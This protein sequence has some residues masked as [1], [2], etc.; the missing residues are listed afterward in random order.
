MARTGGAQQIGHDPTAPSRRAFGV[1]ATLVTIS[2]LVSIVSSLGAP[3]IPTIAKAESVS[4]ST[5]QWLLTAALLAGALATPVMGRLSDGPRQREVVLAA[6]GAVLVGCLL[7]AV[8]NSFTVVVVGRGLQGV[9][10]GLLPVTMAI[11]RRHLPVLTAVRAIAT[12]SI[13]A[14]IGVGVGYPLTSL[15]AQFF[16]FHAAFWFG[17]IAVS[18]ALLVAALVL[19]GRYEVPT[20]RFDGVGVVSLSLAVVGLSVYLSEGGDWG[21]TSALS[22]SIIGASSVLLALWVA[23][24]LRISDPLVN[25]RQVR[26]RSVLTADITGFLLC[27]AVYLFI[28]VAVEFVQIPKSTGYGFGVSIVVSGLVL[29]PLSVATF[30]ASRLLEPFTRQFG[31]RSM[32]PLGSLIFAAATSFLAWEHRALWEAFVAVG[33]AG[34]GYGFSF[35]AMPGFIVRAVPPGDTGSAMGFYQVLRSIG[36]SAGSALA[37]AVL[38][39]YTHKGRIYPAVGGFRTTLLTASGLCLLAAVLSYVL[40]GADHAVD[41]ASAP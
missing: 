16:D 32:I 39:A 17:A 13:T 23:Y 31:T 25:L 10:L 8:S 38:S 36:L 28:P 29:V 19:P 7:A 26:N 20:R 4:L 3:L 27:V 35:A 2:A 5:G 33:S 37:A 30:V 9:G 11:A 18:A 1:V 15:I 21:W 12:L 40:P 24:E 34:L 6:L 14:A 41:D 22:L